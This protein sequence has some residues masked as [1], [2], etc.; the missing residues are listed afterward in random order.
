MAFYFKQCDL[1]GFFSITRTRTQQLWLMA[2]ATYCV[3]CG[4]NH[5]VTR[6]QNQKLNRHWRDAM[7]CDTREHGSVMHFTR[8]LQFSV[9]LI[10]L[11]RYAL[12]SHALYY[13]ISNNRLNTVCSLQMQRRFE[14]IALLE[15]MSSA[16]INC[17]G[18]C[19]QIE[20]NSNLIDMDTIA[21]D[22]IHSIPSGCCLL[23]TR[24]YYKIHWIIAQLFLLPIYN[25]SQA[26]WY[27]CAC[28]WLIRSL[29]HL[30]ALN[31]CL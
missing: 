14:H 12:I 21:Y 13:S 6:A 25:L 24:Y 30:S 1:L 8:H 19:N 31:K 5:S 11:S 28:A 4:Q 2:L 27:S 17:P 16:C 20:L 26:I 9:Y 10:K 29:A 3:P 18:N 23:F 15:W 22:A 7:R